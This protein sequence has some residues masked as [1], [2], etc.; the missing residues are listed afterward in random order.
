MIYS[1]SQSE[2][3]G[4]SECDMLCLGVRFWCLEVS[5]LVSRSEQFG[6]SEVDFGFLGQIFPLSNTE[7]GVAE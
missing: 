1:V 7:F 3:F 6:V 4:V 2:I 5:Y